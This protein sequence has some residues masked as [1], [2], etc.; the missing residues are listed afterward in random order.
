MKLFLPPLSSFR[1]FKKGCCQIL[2]KVFVLHIDWQK[3][4]YNQNQS[5]LIQAVIS[6]N[7]EIYH[8]KLRAVSCFEENS[9]FVQRYHQNSLKPRPKYDIT[10]AK[11]KFEF[12][13]DLDTLKDKE[14]AR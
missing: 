7:V 8:K 5:C 9:N 4:R 6:S 2:S 10:D 1:W 11:F 3:K 12:S 14:G 13:E